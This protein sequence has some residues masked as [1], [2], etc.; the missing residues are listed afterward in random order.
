MCVPKLKV[1]LNL[2]LEEGDKNKDE[3]KKETDGEAR[4]Y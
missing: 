2:L 3:L 1:K 4:E